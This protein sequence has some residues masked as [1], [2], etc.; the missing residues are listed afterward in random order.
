VN[1]VLS[2]YSDAH[3]ARC[4]GHHFHGGFYVVRVQV[5]HLQLCDLADLFPGD[6]G[7]LGAMK[8]NDLSE[9]TVMTTGMTSPAWACVRAL[10]CLQN[11]M[12]FTPF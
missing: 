11:S 4:A 12:M 9:K 2:L 1:D 8:V 7:H 3:A 10:N 5:R 6:L